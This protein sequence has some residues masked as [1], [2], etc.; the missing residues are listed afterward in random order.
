MD[1]LQSRIVARTGR[2]I[3]LNLSRV[4]VLQGLVGLITVCDSSAGLLA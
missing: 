2:I 1:E 4:A 3:I